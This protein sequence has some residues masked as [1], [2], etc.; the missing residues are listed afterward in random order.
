[1]NN[2][3]RKTI[4]KKNL[5]KRKKKI[6][7]LFVLSLQIKGNSV[8]SK[9]ECGIFKMGWIH[10]IPVRLSKTFTTFL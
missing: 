4:S 9:L 7:F 2:R 5:L 8:S 3:N 10:T 1:M 6:C